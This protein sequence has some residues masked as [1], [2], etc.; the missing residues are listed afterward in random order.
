MYDECILRMLGVSFDD[1]LDEASIAA[2]TSGEFMETTF[3]TENVVPQH[4]VQQE[5]I[6]ET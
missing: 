6:A 2:C 5:G 4:R 3:L 1:R